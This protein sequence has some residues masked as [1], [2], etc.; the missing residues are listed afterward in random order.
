VI[1]IANHS[2]Q[3]K[4]LRALL[5]PDYVLRLSNWALLQEISCDLEVEFTI[6][7]FQYTKT[8]A[9]SVDRNSLEP[10]FYFQSC[11]GLLS[12]S[13]E[14]ESKSDSPDNTFA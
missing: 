8:P 10:H 7:S 2:T 3:L 13:V 12:N 14:V 11:P 9:S 1:Y 4:S 6:Q 5:T